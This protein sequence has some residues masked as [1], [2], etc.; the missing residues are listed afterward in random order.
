MSSL[1]FANTITISRPPAD[2]FAYLAAFENVPRWNYAIAETRKLGEA[3][4][5]VG[6]RYRQ[7]RT[8]PSRAEEYFEVIEFQPQ[9]EL[10]IRGD[11]GPFSGEI[12]YLLEETPDGTTL[13][14]TCALRA[15]GATGLLAPLL[16]RQVSSAVAAN[17]DVLRQLLE[18][19]DA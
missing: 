3:P 7:L 16:T 19:G 9:R 15:R 12:A 10:A 6:T 1:T 2:V 13:T 5:G 4:V 14:N 11:I 8:I 18:R 17:L